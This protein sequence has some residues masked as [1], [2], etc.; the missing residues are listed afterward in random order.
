MK[1][2]IY[3]GLIALIALAGC[4]KLSVDAPEFDV[5]IEKTTYKVGEEVNFRFSGNPDLI[6]VYRGIAGE[7]YDFRNRITAEGLP[8]L[9]FT[10]LVQNT[11]ET[12]TLRLMG[13]TN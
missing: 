2:R 1:H 8:Q 7:N 13:S 12:N 5:S 10:T 11:G 9:N 6:S 4:K 3:L